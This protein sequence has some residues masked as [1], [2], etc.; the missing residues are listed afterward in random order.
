MNTRA[1]RALVRCARAANHMLVHYKRVG[2][3]AQAAIWRAS[4]RHHINAA[5][6][7]RADE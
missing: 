4:C 7:M 5:R 1:I 2:M 3:T 6:L